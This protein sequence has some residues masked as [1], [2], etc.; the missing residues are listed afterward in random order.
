M[1]RRVRKCVFFRKLD[2]DGTQSLSGY[3]IHGSVY[4]VNT[5]MRLIPLALRPLHTRYMMNKR[6]QNVWM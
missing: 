2:R 3:C 4:G 6:K 5:E 1:E